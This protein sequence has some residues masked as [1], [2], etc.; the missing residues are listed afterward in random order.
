MARASA[1]RLSEKE[2]SG[3]GRNRPAPDLLPYRGHFLHSR[4]EITAQGEIHWSRTARW[5][6][7]SCGQAEPLSPRCWAFGETPGHRVR[8]AA[9]ARAPGEVLS[10]ASTP[11]HRRGGDEHHRRLSLCPVRRHQLL[12]KTIKKSCAIKE[13]WSD[14]AVKNE[15]VWH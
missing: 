11:G 5:L 9:K 15:R 14:A 2:P 13:V 8:D 12:T 1:P 10:G 6:C 4:Y 3:A 7:P